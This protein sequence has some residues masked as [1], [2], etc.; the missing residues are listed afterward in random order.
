L[1]S[2]LK[3]SSRALATLRSLGKTLDATVKSSNCSCYPT[4]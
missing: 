3:V 4:A 2:P 1:T